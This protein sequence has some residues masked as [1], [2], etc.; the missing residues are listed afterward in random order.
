MIIHEALDTNDIV[1][2]RRNMKICLLTY[3]FLAANK[4]R[5]PTPT[6]TKPH[7]NPDADMFTSK[8]SPEKRAQIANKAD[9]PPR[10]T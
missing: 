3:H 1:E 8:H 7:H 10:T 6:Y 2:A 9:N 4:P 5:I